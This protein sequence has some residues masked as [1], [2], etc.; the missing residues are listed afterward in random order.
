[1]PQKPESVPTEVELKFKLAPEA[2][3]RLRDDPI[4]AGSSQRRQLN[5]VYYDTPDYEL[6]DEGVSLRVRESDGRFVQTVKSRKG[7]ALFN[8]YEWESDVEDGRPHAD[9]L[10]GTPVAK[11]LSD[12]IQRRLSAIFS[13]KVAR[14]VRDLRRDGAI[15]EMSLDEGEIVA[16]D[17]SEPICELELE[18]KRGE[19]EALFDLARHLGC[20]GP[21][22]LSFETKSERG[23]RLAGRDVARAV[24][25]ERT[26]ID[27]GMPAGEAFRSIVRAC[28]TQVS[29]NAERLMIM[30]SPEALHQLRVGLRRL[31]AG[32]GA[33]KDVVGDDVLP[34]VKAETRWLASALNEARDLDVFIRS[35]PPAAE[36]DLDEDVSMKA[37]RRLLTDRQ[38]SAYDGVAAAIGSARFDRL[39]LDTAA[40][41]ETG[42]WATSTAAKA[43]KARKAPT[44]ELAERT[45]TH[46]RRQAL[47]R[48]RKLTELDPEHRHKLRI[49][50]KKLRY[51]SDFFSE[52]VTHPHKQRR[53]AFIGAL[54]G[55]QDCLGELNDVAVSRRTAASVVERRGGAGAGFAAGLIVGRREATE[56]QLL[57]RASEAFDVFA[58]ARKFW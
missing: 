22:R 39:M 26:R 40:W 57:T 8:R 53:E 31:R 23:Y 36:D 13:T 19:P 16:G 2:L 55:L 12:D 50:I 58:K 7:Q 34:V 38:T 52:A 24:K 21:L 51:A 46:L 56:P 30:R 28:L 45:L 4:F 6:R 54:R 41:A 11:V 49:H 33:F 48:G 35:L 14:T 37:F 43:V 44:C 27:A 9:R 32:L 42:A 18:L 5:T 29:G 25:A 3:Q 10:S 1:M 15:V 47:K 17:R 20:E